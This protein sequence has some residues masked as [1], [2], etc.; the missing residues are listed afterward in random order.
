MKSR[1][2]R[3]RSVHTYSGI[4]EFALM[5]SA[6]SIYIIA[7]DIVSHHDPWFSKRQSYKIINLSYDGI[8][9]DMSAVIASILSIELTGRNHR[10][11]IV[12]EG[13]DDI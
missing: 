13:I 6:N 8:F 2:R 12:M 4:S 11:S 9:V 1:R 7:Y 5:R 3:H 10:G